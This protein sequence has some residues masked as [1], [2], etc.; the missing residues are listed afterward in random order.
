MEPN[1]DLLRKIEETNKSLSDSIKNM[2]TEEQIKD[3][4]SEIKIGIDTGDNP[5]KLIFIKNTFEN[6]GFACVWESPKELIFHNKNWD[7][8]IH[9]CLVNMW[10]WKNNESPN[11]PLVDAIINASNFEMPDIEDVLKQVEYV[12]KQR[13]YEPIYNEDNNI[14]TKKPSSNYQKITRIQSN[15]WYKNIKYIKT[16][17]TPKNSGKNFKKYSK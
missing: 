14:K 13:E 7:N 15:K 16:A 1:N 6:K 5:E 9:V 8:T 12:F 3:V 4:L 11:N 10:D 17:R 2:N